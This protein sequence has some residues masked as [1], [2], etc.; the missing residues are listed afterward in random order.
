MTPLNRKSIL[1]GLATISI[2]SPI[3]IASNCN[4]GHGIGSPVTTCLIDTPLARSLTES[5]QGWIAIS[6][7]FL[8]LPI[9]VY[10]SVVAAILWLIDVTFLR[11][12]S[13]QNM[14]S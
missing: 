14:T 3:I 11:P 5:I 10:F 13:K 12:S 9:F 6:A 4:G 2:V 1:A 8:G 7:F